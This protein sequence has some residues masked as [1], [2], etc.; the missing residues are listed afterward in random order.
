MLTSTT[1]RR[2]FILYC[3]VNNFDVRQREV[4]FGNQPQVKQSRIEQTDFQTGFRVFEAVRRGNFG[5]WNGGV[6]ELSFA[7]AERECREERE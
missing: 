2:S 6:R 1:S 3:D 5:K 7:H 4:A